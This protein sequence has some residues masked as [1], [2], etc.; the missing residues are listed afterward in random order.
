MKEFYNGEAFSL[1]KDQIIGTF[2]MGGLTD[3]IS[4]HRSEYCQ[5]DQGKTFNVHDMEYD[6]PLTYL[7]GVDGIA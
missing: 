5:H 3:I 6:N 2:L 7:R 1:W 4:Q